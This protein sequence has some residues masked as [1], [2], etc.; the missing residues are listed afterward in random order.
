MADQS[1]GQPPTGV[2]PQKPTL[3]QQQSVR[4]AEDQSHQPKTTRKPR[5]APLELPT[6]A[7]E[8][9]LSKQDSV[10]RSPF[11]TPQNSIQPMDL[12]RKMEEIMNKG[13]IGLT[14]GNKTIYEA[15]WERENSLGEP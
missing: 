7:Q 12:N 15:K 14:E 11:I 6:T 8:I 10:K 3:N 9:E 5:P 1:S 4:F 2:S 13:L